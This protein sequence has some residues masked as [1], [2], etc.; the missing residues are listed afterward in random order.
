M[1][2]PIFTDLVELHSTTVVPSVLSKSEKKF[3]NKIT[4]IVAVVSVSPSGKSI[5]SALRCWNRLEKHQCKGY[6][7]IFLDDV[8]NE[9]QWSCPNCEMNGIIKK[10]RDTDWDLSKEIKNKRTVESD[11]EELCKVLI[12]DREYQYLLKEDIDIDSRIIILKARYTNKGIQVSASVEDMRSFIGHISSK[13]EDE[14]S[15]AKQNTFY[16][17]CSKIEKS[18]NKI[19]D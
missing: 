16:N 17:I 4:I 3:I 8:L 19:I 15:T 12:T 11:Y 2:K 6:I 18:I 7:K 1:R 9:I 14:E 5:S 13:A 10:W